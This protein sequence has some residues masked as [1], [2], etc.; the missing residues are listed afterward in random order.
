MPV[1]EEIL[2]FSYQI[3]TKINLC[4]ILFF[5]AE[6]YQNN[7][8]YSQPTTEFASSRSFNCLSYSG[9]VLLQF[10]SYLKLLIYKPFH[11]Q[12][13]EKVIRLKLCVFVPCHFLD[14]ICDFLDVILFIFIAYSIIL[15][16][17]GPPLYRRGSHCFVYS[18]PGSDPRKG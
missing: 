13:R 8:N 12:Y 4:A 18:V 17:T 3:A 11:C 10:M 2:I 14:F 15:H 5:S 6:Q 1:M 16:C 9:E 7:K